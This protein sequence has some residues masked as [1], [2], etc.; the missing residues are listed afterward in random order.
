MRRPRSTTSAWAVDDPAE[1]GLEDALEALAVLAPGDPV[2]PAAEAATRRQSIARAT[3]QMTSRATRT[4]V[5]VA[6]SGTSPSLAG[7]GAILCRRRTAAE[8]TW[9][10]QRSDGQACARD[11]SSGSA[12]ADPANRPAGRQ[13]ARGRGRPAGRPVGRRD[14]PSRRARRPAI[15]AGEPAGRPAPAGG[16]ARAKRIRQRAPQRGL[17]PR[18]SGR[19][20]GVRPPRSIATSPGMSAGSP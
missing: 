18:R 1:V 8:S 11:D 4:S 14:G 9:R 2:E 5:S 13:P 20:A 15:V 12:P 7:P 19:P 3:R 6:E 17:A 16:P 10:N